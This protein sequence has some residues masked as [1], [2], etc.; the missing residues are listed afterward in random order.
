[1]PKTKTNKVANRQAS[2]VQ[3]AH[4][5][6]VVRTGE[7]VRKAAQKRQQKTGVAGFASEFP[8]LTGILSVAILAGLFSILFTNHLLFFA[9]KTT[10]D[11]CVW[12]K[13]SSS[14]AAAGATITRHYSAAPQKCISVTTPGQYRA[15]IHTAKGDIIAVLDQTQ[16]PITVNNFVFL[17]THHF[18]DG[19]TFDQATGFTLSGGDPRSATKP[20]GLPD[21]TDNS[22]GPGYTIGAELPSSVAAYQAQSIVMDNSGK[23]DTAGSRF[24]VTTG[25][26]AAL[27]LQFNYF[28]RITDDSFTVAKQIKAGEK[29]LSITIT[30]DPNG[31]PGVVVPTPTPGK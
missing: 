21:V 18:Y 14:P 28:G 3:Q 8:W 15:T 24:F 31:L 19:L 20:T 30:F 26:A 27:P 10:V 11:A 29:I 16:A 7:M 13:Q 6:P 25:N 4:T 22:N 12:A 9:P 2:R 17:A 5:T 23:N 1:M